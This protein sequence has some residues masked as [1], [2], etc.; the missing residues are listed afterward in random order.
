MSTALLA[1]AACIDVTPPAGLPMAGFAARTSP[2]A[3]THDPLTARAV[4]VGDTVIVTA[5]V[6]GLHEDSCLRIRERSTLPESNVVVTAVHTHGGPRTM[7]GRLGGYEQDYLA[8]LEDASVEAVHQALAARRPAE[9]FFGNG[10]DPGIAKNRRH[11]GG[12]TDPALPVLRIRG[13][14][15]RWIAVILAYACH[16]VVLGPDNLLWTADYP[17]Y[18][19]AGLERAHEGAV[20]LFLTGCTADANTGHTAHASLS[21]AAN[22]NRTFEAA[23]RYAARVIEAAQKAPMRRIGSG[24]RS[25]SADLLLA[26][27]RRERGD[28][29]DLVHLW[30]HEA[31]SAEPT[32]AMLLRH[33]AQWG[34]T[35]ARQPLEPWAGRV[36]AFVWGGVR[37][38]FLPGEI[39]ARTA[40]DIRQAVDEQTTGERTVVAAFTD[41]C[42][43]YIPPIGEFAHG[44]YE[45]DE[46]HRYYGM[47]A[48]FAPGSAETIADTAIRLASAL[49]D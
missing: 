48:T 7:P 14:D 49:D 29:D 9:V 40:L 6:V 39:F 3:G 35:I 19:R 1:G 13:L 24:I 25:A 38:L 37:L 5:D 32:R 36:T 34:E 12:E 27:E 44:G 31:A 15:G 33:W 10:D 22:P 11:P 4:A 30:R 42:P 21:T 41:G 47:P 8:T 2:A 17:G 23:E 20:S 43:G 26:F 45:V 28:L 46:A 16:P 18:V